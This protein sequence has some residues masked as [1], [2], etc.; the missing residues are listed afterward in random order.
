MSAPIPPISPFNLPP[1][2]PRPSPNWVQLL[3]V[4]IL[5][6]GGGSV[7]KGVLE[8][9]G[10]NLTNA[11]LYML[12]G[13]IFSGVGWFVGEPIRNIAKDERARFQNVLSDSIKRRRRNSKAF[14]EKYRR[15][16]LWEASKSETATLLD[17]NSSVALKD[18]FVELSVDQDIVSV[19]AANAAPQT[20]AHQFGG[21]VVPRGKGHERFTIWHFLGPEQKTKNQAIV[22]LGYPGSGKTTLLK[23]ITLILLDPPKNKKYKQH[24]VPDIVPIRIVLR[25]V[26]QKIIDS[27]QKPIPDQKPF[28]DF[29]VE[30]LAFQRADLQP[31]REWF[32]ERR[33]QGKLL[34]MFDGLDEIADANDRK[35]IVEWIDQQIKNSFQC[36]FIISSRPKGYEDNPLRHLSIRIV[37]EPL[38]PKQQ[39]E[40]IDNWNWMHIQTE[41]E[42]NKQN[43]EELRQIAKTR[44]ASLVKQITGSEAEEM[45]G[46]PMLL[47]MIMIMF[48]RKQGLPDSRIQL[49]KNVCEVSFTRMVDKGIEIGMTTDQGLR[50]L[51][52]LA[53]QMTSD[54][55]LIIDDTA[56]STIIDKELPNLNKVGTLD[57]TKFLDQIVLHSGLLR[58]KTTR[59][60]ET[61][62][63]LE[64]AHKTLQEFLTARFM[65]IDQPEVHQE[66]IIKQ[67]DF[68]KIEDWWESPIVMYCALGRSGKIIAAL[69]KAKTINSLSI[70]ID[71]NDVARTDYPQNVQQSYQQTLLEGAESDNIELRSVVSQAMLQSELR[72]MR[73]IGEDTFISGYLTNG[74]YQGFVID[75]QQR[76]NEN[77]APAHWKNGQIPKGQAAETVVGI[78]PERVQEFCIWLTKRTIKAERF[79]LPH[80]SEVSQTSSRAKGCW[81]EDDDQIFWQST[82]SANLSGNSE[83]FS[84]QDYFR[85]REFTILI[86]TAQL[87]C[88]WLISVLHAANVFAQAGTLTRTLDRT[89]I[90]FF[91]HIGTILRTLDRTLAKIHAFDHV[92]DVSRLLV[93]AFAV[94]RNIDSVRATAITRDL[95]IAQNLNDI[96]STAHT[97][98]NAYARDG[99]FVSASGDNFKIALANPSKLA[100]ELT[101]G[102][103]ATI[104]IALAD[105]FDEAHDSESALN[106]ASALAD[107]LASSNPSSAAHI[108][109]LANVLNSNGNLNN[110][111]QLVAHLGLAA[112]VS[113]QQDLEPF[114]M[115]WGYLMTKL[116]ELE[117]NP[118]VAEKMEVLEAWQEGFANLV[119][120]KE[121]EI[122]RL[123]KQRDVQDTIKVKQ[124][125]IARYQQ[126]QGEF[127]QWERRL[128]DN[129]EPYEGLIIVR[130]PLMHIQLR[131]DL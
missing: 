96:L 46:S 29:L 2:S 65:H 120:A 50:V 129:V 41:P 124:D 95:A 97:T 12:L 37:L 64:F 33:L 69:L 53:L 70:A 87:T 80:A 8:A 67:I 112:L 100:S 56:A 6:G 19:E 13:L 61:V 51:G 126:F 105:A 22:I 57:S 119:E 3:S 79:R 47:T 92:R 111:R 104:G 125:E 60:L 68:G 91:T 90:Q 71:C 23:H 16:M 115:L 108:E 99:S 52:A 44:S 17:Y 113:S 1:Q 11:L 83:A 107:A 130:E 18:V 5:V 131:F 118:N 55:T 66:A 24:S 25:D 76:Y 38:S 109:I 88:K 14:G 84:A 42:A 114:E 21:G 94:G 4:L 59:E 26:G 9:V 81:I 31:D 103:A 45:T 98:A 86:S 28:V 93:R 77:Y 102:L 63:Q 128:R 117:S 110:V 122:A 34:F 10:G 62:H 127:A 82:V 35:V 74:A 27:L 30:I 73:R 89:V 78:T 40:L 49:Y 7:L 75:A 101:S 58:E 54:G 121:Q 72:T 123:R 36:Q 32:E 85:N 39:H 48:N 15:F 106:S 43:E 116:T 20:L